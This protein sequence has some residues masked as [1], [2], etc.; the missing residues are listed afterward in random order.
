MKFKI[1]KTS[2][3]HDEKPCKEAYWQMELIPQYTGG[4]R[5]IKFWFIDIYTLEDLMSFC[6]K[7]KPLILKPG[8]IEIYDDYRE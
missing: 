5:N 3:F 2:A 7:Y 4:F 8:S 6:E 1:H